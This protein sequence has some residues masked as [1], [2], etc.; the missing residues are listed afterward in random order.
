MADTGDTVREWSIPI[1]GDKYSGI[2]AVRA[3]DEY[4]MQ[5]VGT[6]A[7]LVQQARNILIEAGEIER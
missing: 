1:A 3:G 6:R 7:Q 5:F 4:V 2:A